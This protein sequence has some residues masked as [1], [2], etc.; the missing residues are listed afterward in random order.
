M[1]VA[2]EKRRI[3]ADALRKYFRQ[4]IKN[5]DFAAMFPK[6]R[7]DRAL[8]AIGDV[9]WGFYSDNLSHYMFNE[10]RA[11]LEVRGLYERCILFLESDQEYEWPKLK[12]TPLDWVRNLVGSE[13][14]RLLTF[15]ELAG[16]QDFEAW[17]FKNQGDLE[18]ARQSYGRLVL[19]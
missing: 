6:A 11:K 16:H 8:A 18:A 14:G 3:A 17:P 7:E 13:K 5:D 1:A 12:V 10:T 19:E 4:E 2:T 15:K 9:M